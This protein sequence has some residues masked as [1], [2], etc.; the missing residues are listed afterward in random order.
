MSAVGVL[1]YNGYISGSK[2]KSAENMLM[3]IGLAQTEYY[4]NYGDYFYS[5]GGTAEDTCEPSETFSEEIGLKLFDTSKYIK[6]EIDYDFCSFKTTT[7]FEV[8]AKKKG[9][10][11]G[12]CILIL[13]ERGAIDYSG[14]S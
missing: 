2:K 12:G 9:A 11:V 8:H 1:S 10:E 3:Q 5:D 4:S 7:G 6:P 14:C 13:D